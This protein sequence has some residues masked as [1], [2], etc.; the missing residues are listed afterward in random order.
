[1]AIKVRKHLVPKSKW[2]IKCP[3]PLDAEF[4]TYHN[5]YNDVR[6]YNEV[7][8]MITNNNQVSYHFAIDEIE[9]VQGIETNRNAWACGDG[10]SGT[11][12]RK[13]I[14]VEVCYSK[15]GGAKYDKAEKL[16]NK[17]IAQLLFERGWGVDRVK[18]HQYWSGKFCPHR[19]LADSRWNSII[20]DIQKEL[21]ALKGGKVV[22]TAPPTFKGYLDKGDE[23]APVKELQV[24]LNEAG[25]KLKED[26]IFGTE[27]EKALIKFQKANGLK[28]DGIAGNDTFRIL[29]IVTMPKPKG[30]SSSQN[31]SVV[32]YLASKGID[33]SF[34]N[35]EKL[36]KQYGIKGYK[37]SPAQNLELLA[38]LK[39][40]LPKKESASKPASK[41]KGDMKTNSIVEYLQSI[42][43]SS[44]MSNRKKLASKHGIR[45]YKGTAGQNLDLLEILRGGSAPK[46]S[47]SKQV[48][49]INSIGKIRIVGVSNSAIIM[50]RANRTTA[51][52]VG[53][54]GK[55]KE[56]AIAGSTDGKNNPNGYWEVI[57]KGER[58]YV[59]GQF[60]KFIP[61]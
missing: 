11:G 9:V 23:G 37:G 34:T 35:R 42:G 2:D 28:A 53:T 3:Y 30:D 51:K 7:N 20:A 52:R 24:L 40:G 44:S 21:N 4:I 26:G 12:N 39:K 56:I 57:Y 54:I 5:T 58:A 49:G 17:F 29:E 47:A 31:M 45:N 27:T 6:A 38:K 32:D 61:S 10:G 19:I 15:N 60:G 46:P 8:Y 13:S 36:A 50:D 43:E 41:P 16:A 22:V 48:S 59:S 14:S 18:P 33:H 25:A 1:V 55:G